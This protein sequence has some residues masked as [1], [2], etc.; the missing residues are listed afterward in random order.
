MMS[1]SSLCILSPLLFLDGCGVLWL[2]F[3]RLIASEGIG[4]GAACLAVGVN[5]RGDP[6][7]SEEES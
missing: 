5:L 4:H 7:A 2:R 1:Q 6:V 3:G